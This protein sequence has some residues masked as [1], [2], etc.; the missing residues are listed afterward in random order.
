ERGRARVISGATPGIIAS[1]N[2]KNDKPFM[3]QMVFGEEL[4][5]KGMAALGFDKALADVGCAKLGDIANSKEK[6]KLFLDTMDRL[7]AT[8]T[9]EHWLKIL[10]GVDIV[11]APINTLL[12]AS[13]D[14]DVIANNYVI[15]VD[16]PRAGRIKEVGL[17]WKF[18]KTPARAG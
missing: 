12:E 10:R 18:H 5:Q 11:S 3:I 6:T 9:R 14:P 2:D 8:N 15:E 7:F 16:H 1:F 4:W 13:K 17:P